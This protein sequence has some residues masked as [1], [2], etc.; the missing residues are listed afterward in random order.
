MLAISQPS[1]IRAA[2]AKCWPLTWSCTT[3]RAKYIRDSTSLYFRTS[4][5]FDC[6]KRIL[7]NLCRSSDCTKAGSVPLSSKWASIVL[8][9]RVPM[10]DLLSRNLWIVIDLELIT[11]H[12]SRNVLSNTTHGTASFA[13]NAAAF[14]P[15]IFAALSGKLCVGTSTLEPF[16]R[17]REPEPSPPQGARSPR[18]A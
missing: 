2:E 12:S 8:N 10:R 18:Q 17:G 7:H 1:G 13:W 5:L 14:A 4:H 6:D 16:S 3:V 15:S 9:Q 11:A